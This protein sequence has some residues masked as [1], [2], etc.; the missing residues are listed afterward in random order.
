MDIKITDHSKEILEAMQKQAQLGLDAVGERAEGYAKSECP[1][2]TGRLRNS[3]TYATETNHSEGNTNK[4]P[5]G[6]EDAKPEDYAMKAKPE[7]Y[8]L[9]VGTNVEYARMQEYVSMAH[10]TGKDHFLRDAITNHQDEYKKIMQAALD[11]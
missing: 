1:V 10:K 11:T 3:I 4:H 6:Q 9:Y 2:D 7:K 5:N 8:T